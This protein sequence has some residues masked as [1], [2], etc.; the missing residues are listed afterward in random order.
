M[1]IRSTTIGSVTLRMKVDGYNMPVA[2]V[3]SADCSITIAIM[4]FYL[5]A[6]LPTGKLLCVRSG[7]GQFTEFAPAVGVVR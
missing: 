3:Y 7:G 5:R 2:S 1:P 4:H 6:I